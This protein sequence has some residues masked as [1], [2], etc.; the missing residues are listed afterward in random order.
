MDGLG[1]FSGIGSL[2]QLHSD[3]GIAGTGHPAGR[4]GKLD[5]F[6]LIV[7]HLSGN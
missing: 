1:N 7:I 3:G 6:F 5:L 2:T 4:A